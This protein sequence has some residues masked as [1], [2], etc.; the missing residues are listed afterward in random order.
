METPSIAFTEMVLSDWIPEKDTCIY[1]SEED[2]LPEDC[3]TEKEATPPLEAF[4][5]TSIAKFGNAEYVLAMF[6]VH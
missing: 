3:F 1:Y 6:V 2:L 4:M 5:S